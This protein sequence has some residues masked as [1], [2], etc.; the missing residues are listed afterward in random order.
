MRARISARRAVAATLLFALLAVSAVVLCAGGGGTDKRKTRSDGSLTINVEHVEDGYIQARGTATS[1][2]LKLRIKKGDE[3]LT[4]DLNGEG[5]YETFP[6]QY[7]SGTYTCT[8]Y[9]N[10]SGSR[11]SQEGRV[12][13]K[14]ALKDENAPFLCSN[15]YVDYAGKPDVETT[16]QEICTSLTTER[17]KYDA[18]CRFVCTQFGFDY[19]GALTD[20]PGQL[21]DIEKCLSQRMGVCQ[22]LSA[23]TVS[24]LRVEGIPAKLVIGYADENYHAWVTAEVDGEELLFDPTAELQGISRPASYTVERF[25]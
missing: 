16:A 19:I 2:R 13:V 7:G 18:I 11:Y 17:E 6:L 14:A 3:V 25:Y 5:E 20:K 10:T 21:P 12:T 4:Y 8:L 23:V 1:K 22:D 15:Q 24:L 9:R